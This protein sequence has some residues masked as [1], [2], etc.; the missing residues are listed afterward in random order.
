MIELWKEK[1]VLIC[2]KAYPEYSKK[3]TETV[4][5]AGILSD[6]KELI[7]IYPLPYRYLGKEYQFSKYQ[8]IKALLSKSDSDSRPESYK[9]DPESIKLGT[10]VGSG[11]DGWQEREKW[12]LSPNNLF[13]SLEELKK[14]R[15]ESGKS[16]GIIMPQEI[17]DFKIT[18][19]TES[20]IEEAELKKQG[21]MKQLDMLREKKDLQ[22]VPLRFVLHFFCENHSCPGH[23][24]SILD[25]EILELYRKVQGDHDWRDKMRHKVFNEICGEERDTHLILGN[26]A[27]HPHVFCILGFF[28]PPFRRQL[29][30]F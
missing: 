11:S 14:A 22:Q 20:T 3:Y 6:S 8:W 12:V 10:K 24:L 18:K 19:K 9:I 4:C 15:E 13:D 23:S 27:S 16:L 17:R 30:L 2:V 5:T 21:I 26:I 25:W 29:K 28:W 1:E 7:R